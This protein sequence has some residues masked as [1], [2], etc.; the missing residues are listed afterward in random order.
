M[1]NRLP[2]FNASQILTEDAIDHVLN[3]EGPPDYLGGHRF[4]SAVIGKT[5]FPE[6]WT[7]EDIVTALRITIEHPAKVTFYQHIIR[8]LSLVD[9]VVIEVEVR[10]TR[11]GPRLHKAYP[12]NG[13]GVMRN[14]P[15][16]RVPIPLDLTSLE[17]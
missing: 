13:S 15:I 1:L 12:K 14:D 5:V 17:S 11:R 10:I 9:E 16:K 7:D 6:H 8:L 3:G 2:R 4:E